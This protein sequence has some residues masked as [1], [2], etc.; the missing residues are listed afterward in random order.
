[1][2]PDPIPPPAAA[3]PIAVAKPL[4]TPAAEEPVPEAN[5]LALLLAFV[6][7]PRVG[8]LFPVRELLVPILISLIEAPRRC[9]G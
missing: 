4:T 3:P 5:W 8:D 2:R 7:A 1:M 6:Q 9:L